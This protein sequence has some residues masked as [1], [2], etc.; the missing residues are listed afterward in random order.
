MFSSLLK[1]SI[2]CLNQLP[3][4]SIRLPERYKNAQRVQ[5][6]GALTLQSVFITVLCNPSQSN[7]VLFNGTPNTPL[8]EL[9]T[10]LI[11]AP[12]IHIMTLFFFP[13]TTWQLPIF[14]MQFVYLGAKRII[15]VMD[16]KCLV[17]M[18]CHQT[19]HDILIQAHHQFPEIK[20]SDYPPAWYQACRSGLDFYT[21]PKDE[22]EISEL[23]Q[24]YLYLWKQFIVLLKEP[25]PFSSALERD[26]YQKQL[27]DYKAHH[28]D[29]SPGL[30]LL[31]R[32]FGIE[33]TDD[34]F[35]NYLFA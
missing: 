5:A 14:A 19:V 8:G 29:H 3:T 15:G 6:Q 32:S 7:G 27:T 10:V 12:K 21:H 2:E 28:R 16:I 33:W 20:T 22:L 4:Q 9:R 18:C 23:G 26:L 31:Q 35:W 30:P 13:Q 34:F 25:E 11:T 1:Q 24:A 17:A